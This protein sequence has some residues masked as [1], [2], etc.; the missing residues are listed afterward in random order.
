M[1]RE[2]YDVS[3]VLA[4]RIRTVADFPAEGTDFY[5][6]TPVLSDPALLTL[7]VD[8]LAVTGRMGID[9]VA[10]IES[11]GYMLA[12]PI[13]YRLGAGF[14]PLGKSGRLPWRTHGVD[15]AQGD[16]ADR[17]EVHEDAFQSGDRVLIV[18][19]V[20]ATGT[21]AAAAVELIRACGAVV[22]GVSVLL[23]L[24]ALNGRRRLPEVDIRALH[25]AER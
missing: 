18:D 25:V 9:K 4:D 24:P 13:A 21:T 16:A 11:W 14:V 5:D 19:D 2:S 3:G 7:V 1:G 17:L 12:A 10:G 20:L 23:E 22:V 6:I 8:A 15:Y